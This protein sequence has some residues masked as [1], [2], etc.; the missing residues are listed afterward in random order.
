MP[1]YK[2]RTLLILLA[3]LPPVF[4]GLYWLAW[5]NEWL[6]VVV[7]SAVFYGSFSAAIL[8]NWLQRRSSEGR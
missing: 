5:W 6:T 3:V 8:L 1:R 7:V 4:G 2:L